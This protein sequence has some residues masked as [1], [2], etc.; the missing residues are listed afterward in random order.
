MPLYVGLDQF[1]NRGGILV[2]HGEAPYEHDPQNKDSYYVTL[3]TGDGK[4]NTIWGVDLKRA[5]DEAA[6]QIGDRIGLDHQGSQTVRLTD[7]KEVRRHQWK[8]VDV[9]ALALSRMT[10]RL[11]RDGSKE[12]TLDYQYASFYRSALRFAETR[13]LN[14]MSV[15]RTIMR[16]RLRWTVRQ[17]ER[18]ASLG[19]RLG[20][21]PDARRQSPTTV[22]TE[23]SPMVAGITT[24][25]K[26]LDRAVEDKLAADPSLKK[27][28]EEVS[29]RF[30]LIY[31]EPEA[32]FRAVNVD[33]MLADP[34]VAKSTLSKI[35]NETQSF[36]A[37]KGRTGILASRA[38]REAWETA[39]VNAPAL[40]RDLARYLQMRETATQ[41]I[42]AQERALRHRVS[43]DIP[44]LSP[45][46]RTVLER[47]RDAIDR[48]DL[49]AALGY[50]MSDKEAKL[51]I[52]GFNKAVA[53]RFGERR[54][55]PID[56]NDLAGKVFEQVSRGLQ[57]QQKERLAEAWPIMRAAQQLAASRGLPQGVSNFYAADLW[58]GLLL[59]LVASIAFVAVHTAAWAGP[60]KE[61]RPGK[62]PV[63][64]GRAARYLAAVV[65]MALPPFGITGWAQ[66]VTAA[67][68]LFPGWGWWG[69][70]AVATGILVMTTRFWPAAAVALGG[71]WL[72]SAATWTQPDL[73]QGWKGVDLEHGANL[74]R[75]GSL[76]HH[77]DLIATVRRQAEEGSRVVVLPESALG[78][79]TP[80]VARVWRD[81][82]AGLD[83]TVVVGAAVVDAS[84][85]DNV[86]VAISEGET[87]VLYRERMPVPVSMWQPWLAW[88]GQGGGARAHFFANPV[89]DLAGTRVAPLICYEQLIL[90]PALQSLLHGPDIIVATGNGWWTAGTSIVAIQRVSTIAWAKLFG[91]PIVM[92]FNI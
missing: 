90:W 79:W 25:P 81:G 84:G 50:A 64:W 16:D 49:P 1:T 13:G 28:W 15:A 68:V 24:H 76:R 82:L 21:V 41:W 18:L 53:E 75:D 11:S 17:K 91:T 31:A 26:S 55:L 43:I 7:G 58:P 85:Y 42:E 35:G 54:L 8:V 60:P 80:T 57:P 34:T 38:D 77:R 62:G 23:T 73:P 67:G 65:L 2:D 48:N 4:Q 27:Q 52:D 83:V 36:G 12:T 47:V 51:E 44:A 61:G 87:R 71:V 89:V 30:R 37:L 88:T 22:I 78:F 39:R 45:T 72:W 10:E 56:A 92:A 40:A 29:T 46:A 86:M 74:G 70:A 20:L 32:A 69:L 19:S 14:L 63:G 59:W 6:P 3:E 9:R 33:A 5:I 66:P